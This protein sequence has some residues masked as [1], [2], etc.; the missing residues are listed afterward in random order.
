MRG[1]ARPESRPAGVEPTPG[2]RILFDMLRAR[3]IVATA[4]L[5]VGAHVALAVLLF[6]LPSVTARAATTS[7]PYLVEVEPMGHPEGTP[8]AAQRGQSPRDHDRAEAGGHRSA[9]NIDARDRG[10]GGDATGAEQGILLMQRDEGIV[11]FDSP[12]NNL[13][14]MQ[15]QRIRTARDRATLERRRA[16]PNP[17]DAVFLA[18]GDGTHR[19]RRPVSA[20]DPTQGARRAPVA[21]VNG[22]LPSVART[23]AASREHGAAEG[24]ERPRV[25]A[26][27]SASATESGS[28][29]S[30]G[31]G[32]LGGSGTRHSV[33]A[34]VAHARPSIDEGPA[35]TQSDRLSPRVRD[36]QSAELLAGDLMQSWVESTDRTAPRVGSGR[37]GTG[38][39][40]SPGVGGGQREGGRA[41]THGP[42]DGR[43]AALDTS[44]SR[45]RHWFTQNRRRVHD[46]L[47]FPRERA[48]A[49]DQGV[50]IYDVRVRRDGT[51][52]R[53]PR[54]VRTSGY[55]DLDRAALAAIRAAT[56][57]SPLPD[58]LA[59]DLDMLPLRLPI[60]FSNPMV[61]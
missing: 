5:S 11:L 1:N 29:A 3:P 61:R 50:S 51:L 20:E 36:D 34:D 25:P 17:H 2:R 16:T 21:S 44:D 57:F 7:A 59:P 60:E 49:M 58:D 26:Q 8:G 13:V 47:R 41:T 48:L 14:A 37:G 54:L 52:A 22:A 18:S 15:S 32:I 24:G 19:E 46:A 45:Y 6:R 9:Q 56:P 40:G 55:D 53:A 35:A 27:A 43:Y 33:R 10:Q 39:G 23:G 4:L 12:L 38:G 30:P 31:T 42:G 28:Q